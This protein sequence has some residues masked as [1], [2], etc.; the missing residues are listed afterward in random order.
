MSG[1]KKFC[2]GTK[3]LFTNINFWA[4]HPRKIVLE[5]RKKLY[6]DIQR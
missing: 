4:I 6:A 2:D 1:N 3:N 5:H